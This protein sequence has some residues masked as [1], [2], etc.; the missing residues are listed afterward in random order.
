VELSAASIGEIKT[1]KNSLIAQVV[2]AYRNGT[3]FT[4]ANVYKLQ[5][6]E[7]PMGYTVEQKAINFVVDE[8]GN[9]TVLGKDMNDVAEAQGTSL[10]FSDPETSASFRK[11]DTSG[12]AL[13]GAKL[14]ISGNLC[15]WYKDKG[16]CLR[17]RSICSEGHACHRQHLYDC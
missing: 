16:I 9:V 6:A 12:N 4:A 17:Y 8:Q 10:S 15:G 7:A 11:E 5:E 13:A 2:Q 14:V 3:P 1:T